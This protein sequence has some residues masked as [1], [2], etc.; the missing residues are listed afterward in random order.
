MFCRLGLFKEGINYYYK[1]LNLLEENNSPKELRIVYHNLGNAY[2]G[3][4]EYQFALQY[5]NKILAISETSKS[6]NNIYESYTYQRL[7]QLSI[8]QKNMQRL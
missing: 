5:Y 6:E 1:A 2:C 3:I 7:G 8:K 4:D